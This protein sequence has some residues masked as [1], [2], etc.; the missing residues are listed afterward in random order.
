MAGRPYRLFTAAALLA[1]SAGT[2]VQDVHRIVDPSDR[3]HDPHIMYKEPVDLSDIVARPTVFIRQ[4]V[5][6]RAIFNEYV[7]D[8]V[9]L[10]FHTK[11]DPEH[12]AAFSVWTLDAR[13]WTVE[14]Y[15][16]H[17]DT[18]YIRRDNMDFTLGDYLTGKRFSVL[19]IEGTVWHDF[20]GV[21][22]IEV[23]HADEVSGPI[24]TKESLL[25]LMNAFD[26]AKDNPDG[27]I[28]ALEDLRHHGSWPKP[29]EL[30][31]HLLLGILYK[32]KGDAVRAL[33]NLE[34]AERLDPENM[35]IKAS[36]KE[37]QLLKGR[38]GTTSSL[39][40][41]EPV[42]P[43]EPKKE[44]MDPRA[45]RERDVLQAEVKKR[46]AEIK[47]LQDRLNAALAKSGDEDLKTRLAELQ[48]KMEDAAASAVAKESR[49]LELETKLEKLSADRDALAKGQPADDAEA[50]LLRERLTTADNEIALLKRQIADASKK[51]VNAEILDELKRK[52]ALINELR[53]ENAALTEDLKD[54][55][56]DK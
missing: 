15:V 32:N 17:L 6:F 9:W 31:V 53:K 54:V 14:G 28:V 26:L 22:W 52:D 11:F 49:I 8:N 2:C 43:T 33:Q 36:I 13:L 3:R 35:A 37:L 1:L 51:D 19:D 25:D 47:D 45:D 56:G 38:Q 40:E 16:G 21:P 29:A 48:K 44:S 30:E 42:Q 23:Q 50:K 12:F 46:D 7:T 20:G 4:A 10:P 39:Q 34:E 55:K 18:L 41:P 27:A 24:Y 5:K